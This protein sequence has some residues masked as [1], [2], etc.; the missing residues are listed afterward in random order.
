MPTITKRKISTRTD[1]HIKHPK[2]SNPWDHYYQS[3]S[4]KKLRAWQRIE[5]PICALC[6]LEGRS[7]PAEHVHHKVPFSWFDNEDDRMKALLDPDNLQSLCQEHHVE[8]HRHLERP[9]N[10][11]QTTYYKKIHEQN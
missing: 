7:V 2:N 10:F 3:R 6:A 1:K 9:N 4:Y 8:V 5:H 11:E